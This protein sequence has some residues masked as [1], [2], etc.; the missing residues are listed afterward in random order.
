MRKKEIR[1]S[2]RTE[3]EIRRLAKNQSA[4]IH[5]IAALKPKQREAAIRM[6]MGHLVEFALSQPDGGEGKV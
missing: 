5:E 1:V 3:K 2:R 4:I 6:I